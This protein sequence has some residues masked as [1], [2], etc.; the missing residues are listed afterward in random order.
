[1]FLR[2]TDAVS[3]ADA[4]LHAMSLTGLT[5]DHW[6]TLDRDTAT[7]CAE[8]AAHRVDG[9]FVRLDAAPRPGA[10]HRA[11]IER[12]GDTYALIPG[13]TV[14]VGFDPEAWRPLPEQLASY[15]EESLAGGFGFDEDPRDHLARV[16]SP[17][18]RRPC[19]PS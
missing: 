16:L 7:R 5:L 19:P 17:G 13:G 2:G 10:P 3:V 12:A 6:R 8:E 15:R 18:V 4:R 11:L 9:R 1:M 14:T